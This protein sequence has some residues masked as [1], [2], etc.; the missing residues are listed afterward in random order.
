MATT[1]ASTLSWA[2]SSCLQNHNFTNKKLAQTPIVSPVFVIVAQK[3]AKKTRKVWSFATPLNFNWPHFAFI[4][5]DWVLW[6][7]LMCVC[8]GFV[9]QIILKEDVVDVGKK[10][11]LLDVKAGYYRNFLLPSGKAQIVTASLIK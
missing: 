6:G 3:K 7:F 9:G 11:Q 1:T 10:G 5:F 8:F 2:S 4:W